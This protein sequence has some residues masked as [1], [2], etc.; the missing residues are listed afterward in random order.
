MDQRRFDALARNL[1][2][3]VDRR[4]T[5]RA[6][7]AGALAAVAARAGDEAEA[8]PE[9]EACRRI[10][11]KCNRKKHKC[12]F[13]GRCSKKRCRC[14]RGQKQCRR[15]CIPQGNCC[16][17]AD[18]GANAQC[19]ADGTCAPLLTCTAPLTVCGTDCVDTQT[20]E[21]HCGAC[22]QPCADNETCRD[23]ACLVLVTPSELNGW[24]NPKPKVAYETVAFEVGPG[25]P[26]VGDGSIR[27]KL[28]DNSDSRALFNNVSYAG[29]RLDE[30]DE[31]RYATYVTNGSGTGVVAPAVKLPS[32]NVPKVGGG[33]Q[34]ASF[35]YEPH[36][37]TRSTGSGIGPSVVNLDE[38]QEWDTLAGTAR[39]WATK[40][41]PDPTNPSEFIMCNPNGGNANTAACN[42][43]IYVSWA[44]VMTA[45]PDAVISPGID[46]G[47][48][49][50]TGSGSPQADGYVDYLRINGTTFD[51]EPDA[52]SSAGKSGRKASGR[53]GKTQR[54]GKNR[55]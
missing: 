25:N 31:L 49:I 26:P 12:C 6:A 36:Y 5:I 46:N 43:K 21:D 19:L 50:E 28:V 52:Q 40:D 1:A 38:W 7:I 37:D 42:G 3:A 53:S 4:T 27:F 24:T 29:L 48:Q 33:V 11:S 51:F 54:R 55:R 30:L 10:G 47:L 23:G 41:I 45:A 44:T 8:A 9:A 32:V 17:D 34:F 18:C 14:A 13:G 20:D 16:T 35:V 22:G 15:T 39:W 2:A